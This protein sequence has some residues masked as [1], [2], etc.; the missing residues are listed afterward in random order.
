MLQLCYFWKY[1]QTNTLTCSSKTNNHIIYDQNV[2]LRSK[3]LFMRSVCIP[4]EM[5]MTQ[6]Y[7]HVYKNES[8]LQSFIA[9]TYIDQPAKRTNLIQYSIKTAFVCNRGN[10]RIKVTYLSILSFAFLRFYYFWSA[11]SVDRMQYWWL[12]V[13]FVSLV[14]RVLWSLFCTHFMGISA[15]FSSRKVWNISS[16]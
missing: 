8:A 13:I 1:K 7:L 12:F 2:S 5:F 3:S 15:V 9:L 10:M 4:K 14:R 16:L 11:L 6:Y